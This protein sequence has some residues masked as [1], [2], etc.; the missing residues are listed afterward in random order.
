[1]F[2]NDKKSSG[3]GVANWF[4]SLRRQPKK[5]KSLDSSK[6]L[7]KSCVD[8]TAAGVSGSSE[9]DLLFRTKP[10]KLKFNNNETS[11]GSNNISNNNNNDDIISSNSNSC[12]NCCCKF[13]SKTSSPSFGASSPI[14]DIEQC[15]QLRRVLITNEE[16]YSAIECQSDDIDITASGAKSAQKSTRNFTS[17]LLLYNRKE[18]FCRTTR[19]LT[20]KI[21]TKATING[22]ESNSQLNTTSSSLSSGRSNNNVN[23]SV[24]HRIGLIFNENGQLINRRQLLNAKNRDGLIFDE[25][26]RL[27]YTD[28]DETSSSLTPVSIL[29]DSTIEFIDSSTQNSDIQNRANMQINN[30]CNCAGSK[31]TLSSSLMSSCKSDFDNN[32]SKQ[33]MTNHV[34]VNL[35]HV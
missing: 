7:Q 24:H 6:L 34:F 10:S 29:D 17:N 3:G 28:N 33:V 25:S 13:S 32:Q 16:N 8:L 18:E 35:N 21:V 31:L 1:M 19:T 12:T 22:I 20:T 11:N 2:G 30:K 4:F 5:Q 15:D 26:G 23:N 14:D 9:Q 27:L